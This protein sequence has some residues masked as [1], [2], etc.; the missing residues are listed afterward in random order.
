[1]KLFFSMNG[2][3]ETPFFEG[4]GGGES[5]SRFPGYTSLSQLDKVLRE[6]LATFL[7][8]VSSV[9]LLIPDCQ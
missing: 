1:M 5:P 7:C 4:S 9:A 8:F 2:K 3:A 6:S